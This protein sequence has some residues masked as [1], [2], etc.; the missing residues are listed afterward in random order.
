MV[1]D[2]KKALGE[3]ARE[4]LWWRGASKKNYYSQSYIAGGIEIA[5]EK[6]FLNLTCSV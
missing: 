5:Y 4:N 1:A 2:I 6:L 3:G